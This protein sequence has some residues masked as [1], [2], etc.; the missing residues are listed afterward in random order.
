MGRTVRR[1]REKAD[2]AQ[3]RPR[4]R[5]GGLSILEVVCALAIIAVFAAAGT[6]RFAKAITARRA[7]SAARRLAADLEWLRTTALATST[8]QSISFDAAA[9][10]YSLAGFSDPDLPGTAYTVNLASGTYK[11]TIASINLGG[12][13]VLSFNGYGLPSIGGTI[14]VQSGQSTRTVTIDSTCGAITWQ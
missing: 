9:N 5:R 10:S 4:P 13:T 11:S 1:F 14:V 8:S 3:W 12:V 7:E 6:P 2:R